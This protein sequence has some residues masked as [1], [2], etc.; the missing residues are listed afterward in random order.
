MLEKVV[1]ILH[2]FLPT[3]YGDVIWSLGSLGYSKVLR[4]YSLVI[5]LLSLLIFF[6]TYAFL[7]DLYGNIWYR[8]FDT[9][10][11]IIILIITIIIIIIIIIKGDFS[12]VMSDRMLAVLSRVYGKLHV[13]AAAYTLWGYVYIYIYI[14][15]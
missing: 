12:T 9:I 10:I 6:L 11:I 2:T 15:I 3:Q 8:F 13:R 14:H 4:Y 5:N 1:S 7:A